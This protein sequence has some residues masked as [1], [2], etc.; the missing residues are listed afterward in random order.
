MLQKMEKLNTLKDS[1]KETIDTAPFPQVP[2]LIS[3][4]QKECEM[5]KK[6]IEDNEH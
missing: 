2:K 4:A 5:L 6:L 3:E 1:P